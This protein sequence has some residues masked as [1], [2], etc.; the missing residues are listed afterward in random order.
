M[1][2]RGRASRAPTSRSARISRGGPARSGGRIIPQMSR[3][4]LWWLLLLAGAARPAA[5]QAPAER[6]ALQSLRDSLSFVTDS[7]ALRRLEAA[8]ITVARAHRDNPMLHLR[9]GFIAY[10][11]GEIGAVKKSYDDAAGEFEWAAQLRPDW[12]YPWYGLGLAE[13]A[14]GEHS[15]IAIENIRQMLGRDYL[16]KAAKAFA[17]ATQADPSFAVAVVDLV[18]TA[19][20]QRVSPRLAVALEAVRLAAASPAGSDPNLQLARA[21]VEREAGEVDSAIAAFRAALATGG[22]SGVVL[23]ELARTQFFA[24]RAAASASYFAGAASARSPASAGLYRAD[25]AWIATPEELTAFDAQPDAV[26]RAVWLRRFWSRRDVAEARDEGERLAE[27]YRRWFYARQHFRLVSRHRHYDITEVYRS[28]QAEFDDRG[29]IYLR[30][31]EPNRRARAICHALAAEVCATNESWLY[32]RTGGDLI[33]HFVAR[34]DVQDFKLV[35]SLIDVFGFQAGVRAA[36]GAEPGVA[37]LYQTRDQFGDTYRRVAEGTGRAVGP[38]IAQER[39]DGKKDIAVGTTTDSYAQR[40]EQSLDAVA[41]GFI[42]GEGV[43]PATP[44]L[45]VVFAIPAERLSP[46]PGGEGV[47]YPLR[48]R[49]V[50]VDS[51]GDAIARLDTT[52]VFGARQ[53]LRRPSYLT[54]RLALAVPPGRF[55]YR[56][57]VASADG[58]AGELVTLDSAV[59]DRLDGTRFAASDLVLGVQG[60]GLTWV[61]GADTVPLN[62]LGRVVADGDLELYYQLFGLAAGATYHTVI[63]VT[64]E[65]RR[66]IFGRRR[67]PVRLEFEGRADGPRTD[68]RRTVALR[69]VPRGAYR[70][71]IR[72]TDPASGVTLVRARRFTIVAS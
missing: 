5:A 43:E 24:R 16:T 1:R 42:A 69:E 66:S 50:V 36:G 32:R 30:H 37:A 4:P 54:G 12:P 8:T 71:T 22:D 53:A 70:L 25:V 63:E 40:F 27:H 9:L 11:L 47:N 49:V 18:N 55:R 52:R 46:L 2:S 23:L 7:V 38:V 19:L 67:P 14:L 29:V 62:P 35:E 39:S 58:A 3:S 65:G 51:S 64:R 44:M 10:R 56:L 13:L 41:G 26:T 20:T 48:F 28:P 45:H 33:F 34:D 61:T 72:L 68:V 59:A 21:R 6:A 17:R 15:V 60:S 57:L 31:G